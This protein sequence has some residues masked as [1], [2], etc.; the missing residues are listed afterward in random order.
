MAAL[1]G[2]S[3]TRDAAALA[4][5]EGGGAEAAE[6]QALGALLACRV[7]GLV[8]VPQLLAVVAELG[9]AALPSTRQLGAAGAAEGDD[10]VPVE[11]GLVFILDNNNNNNN[12]NNII[13]II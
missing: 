10:G 6:L 3:P 13:I 11:A 5:A 4:V 1:A 9:A 7:T 12:N 8:G 2:G